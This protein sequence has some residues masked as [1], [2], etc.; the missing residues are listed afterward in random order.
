LAANRVVPRELAQLRLSLEGVQAI[1]KILS[2][3][4][5]SRLKPYLEQLNVCESLLE[6]LKKELVE[7]PGNAI[8]KQK[9]IADGVSKELDE[10]RH[11][12]ASGKSYLDELLQ[13]EIKNTGITSLKI[14]DNN[15]FGYYIEVTNAHKDK[16]P[17]EW[18]RKQTLVNAERYI[19]E[20]L[21]EYEAKILGAEEKILKL[22]QELYQSLILDT[23]NYISAIQLNAQLI[24]ELD[25]LLSFAQTALE[26]DYHKPV[27]TKDKTLI[28]KQGR[29]PVIEQQ[30]PVGERYIPN[31]VLLDSDKQQIII[32]TG[33]NMSGKSALLRQTALITLLA[34]IGSFVP[35]KS[36]TI[37]VV[38]KI[39][40]RVGAS[41]N[42]A[43]G[44]STFMVEMMEVASILNNL[45][46]R[47]LILLDEIGRG[48][49]TY[50]GVSIAWAIA[51]YLHENGRVRPKTLFATHYHEL[52]EME[53]SFKRIVNYHVSVQEHAGKILFERTLKKGGTA[54]SFGVHVAEMA[55]VP[56]SVV[57]RSKEILKE[58]EGNASKSG[59]EKPI[60]NMTHHKDGYQLSFFQL[61]DPLLLEIKDII[62]EV[63]VNNLT[64]IEAL[65]V[66]NS[67]QQKLKKKK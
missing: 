62:Q 65:N 13:R 24:A 22:E 50:D 10:L 33:P 44:E 19:T 32:I 14:K 36:A 46:D 15:V 47:S 59:L 8:G 17:P 57:Q 20:E 39:F 67:I 28:I 53:K 56:A 43:L 55:G 16:V 60:D 2:D 66:L 31:D 7:A 30:L 29:H 23:L 34:Q 18:I 37:G 45:S 5:D 11:L 51:E 6:R 48:T 3:D 35:A 42:L 52:N 58:L 38:D 63:D 4:G 61:D 64:P 26:H 25:V 21:K 1:K 40:T 27:I 49:S 9:V 41:D 54:H 12:L